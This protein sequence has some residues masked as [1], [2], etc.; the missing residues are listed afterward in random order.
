M[1]MK[2][3]YFAPFAVYKTVDCDTIIATSPVSIGI[4]KNK[5]G[6]EQLSNRQQGS[7]GNVLNQ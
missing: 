3:E 7:W 1:N 6:D 4:D 5:S 2:K